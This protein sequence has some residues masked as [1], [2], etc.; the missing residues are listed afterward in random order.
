EVVETLKGPAPAAKQMSIALGQE[1]DDD[2]VKSPF[3][4][5]KTATAILFLSEKGDQA[6]ADE[7]DGA[8]LIETLWFAVS[9]QGGKLVLDKDKRDLFAVWAGSARMLAAAAR[10]VQ[11]EPLAE[12][13][14]RSEMSWGESLK[15]GKL[16][17][18]A[19]GCLVADLGKPAGLCAIVL[20]PAGDRV[21]RAAPKGG[22]PG[23]VTAEVK[24]GTASRVAVVGDFTGHGRADLL[25]WDGRS[26]QL[27]AQTA[28][29]TF[30]A[31]KPCGQLA[32]CASLDCIDAGGPRPALV[33]G[34]GQG[35]LLLLWDAGGVLKPQP[36]AA[37][38]DQ[39]TLAKLGAG[40]LCVTA[41]FNA[42]GRTDVMALFTAGALFYAGE[43]PGK[44]KAPR[45]IIV[46]LV[47]QPVAALCGDFDADGSLDVLVAGKDGLAVLSRESPDRWNNVTYL[48]GELAYHGNA[49][50]PQIMGCAPCDVNTDGRQGMTVF[51][52]DR[53]PLLFFNRGFACFGWARELDLDPSATSSESGLPDPLSQP[54]PAGA[55]GPD[56][57]KQGQSCGAI[58]DLNGDGIPDMLA[59]GAKEREVWAVFGRR[60]Q[61]QARRT[62][63]LALPP[64][65]AGPVTVTVRDKGRIAGMYVLRP[66]VPTYVGRPE[67][68]PMTLAWTGRDGKPVSRQ[69][70]VVAS[71][72]RFEIAP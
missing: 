52:A 56:D 46:P 41:D 49:N 57:L 58:M 24:L 40:G 62:C 29:G 43:G 13:P 61:G 45:P 30:A 54:K 16:A 26:L 3:A 63:I 39:E 20:S 66:G 70:V 32:Q 71:G 23:D 17:G 18:P 35:P 15:L 4:G 14:V 60:D 53:K 19:R 12:F 34:T 42:E 33:A 72:S 38:P 51:Y 2:E 67:A 47:D 7:P 37:A 50:R 6:A 9:R 28:D 36:L 68:G 21:Y 55:E 59:V 25:S 22:K 1:L 65:A 11:S 31:P 64:S 69:V 27:A 8:L 5:K 44:F 10:Y 48:T